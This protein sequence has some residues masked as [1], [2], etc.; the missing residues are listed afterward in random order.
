MI[1]AVW[2]RPG[3]LLAAAAVLG[4]AAYLA[5]VIVQYL[6]ERD[7]APAWDMVA[8]ESFLSRLQRFPTL[9][10]A[11]G[12]RDNEHRPVFPLYVFA[13][14]HFYFAS[15]A[16]LPVLLSFL[17]IAG[18]C[19]ACL[20]RLLPAIRQPASRLAYALIFP[21][22]MFW[23]AQYLN[24]VWPKQFHACFSLFC[25]C[26]TFAV[27]AGIDARREEQPRRAETGPL[28]AM[29]ALIFVGTF[30]FGWGLLACPVI[31][32]FVLWQRWPLRHALPVLAA[33]IATL[34]LYAC[35]SQSLN[36]GAGF[37]AGIPQSASYLL[38]FLGSPLSS[39]LDPHATGNEP[40]KIAAE[41]LAAGGLLVSAAL[42]FRRRR[43]RDERDGATLAALN[44]ADLLLAF[45]IVV[46]LATMRVR[47]LRFGHDVN[48]SRYLFI[49]AFFWLSLLFQL[50]WR[51][52]APRLRWLSPAIAALLAAGIVLGTPATFAIMAQRSFDH[53]L[54]GIVSVMGDGIPP[55]LSSQP[56]IINPLFADYAAH[57]ASVYTEPWPHWLGMMAAALAPANAPACRGSII[58]TSWVEQSVDRQI[59][60][61]LTRPDGSTERGW[62]TF[63]DHDGTVIGL[64]TSGSSRPIKGY[65]GELGPGEVFIGYIR[66]SE[67]DLGALY[68]WF[69]GEDWCRLPI[70]P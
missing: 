66:G 43:I 15:R 59:E 67:S 47:L 2:K 6:H 44:L 3:R 34:A 5:L 58:R 42:F 9:G 45:S 60:G 32:G 17:S 37:G 41:I 65:A 16:L 11:F 54:G 30:S 53:R 52:P 68:G 26:T 64:G 1:S 4:S 35:L 21:I 24:F 48:S 40:A 23:P 39:L 51:E 13:I 20:W 36:P 8:V 14:D 28:L 50:A 69:G 38:R 56:E 33:S 57:G 12:F 29:A 61:R 55:R 70:G 19:G 46:A 25:V 10:E 62:L 18:A 27:A 49:P 31:A 63:A 22:V 7:L